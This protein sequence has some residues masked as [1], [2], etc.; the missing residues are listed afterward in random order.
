MDSSFYQQ[1]PSTQFSPDNSSSSDSF[2]SA[3]LPFNENDTQEM[4]LYGI[5]E[6]EEGRGGAGAATTTTTKEEICNY[7][8][9][10]R[11]PWGKYAAEI[12][13][14]TRNGI[15]VWIGTFD[16]AE[17]AA[18]AYDQAAFAMR[19]PSTALN[20]PVEVVYESL[21]EMN[22]GF[23]EGCS[24]VLAM[25]K[26]HSMNRKS[27]TKTTKKRN[28]KNNNNNN[29]VINNREFSSLDNVLVLED[30][31]TDYL[32][33]LLSLSETSAPW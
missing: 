31:G 33:E 19:G 22:Y 16:T 8:G 26:R 27:S 20:F 24:P 7:R 2:N 4:L 25:K 21:K 17:E 23:Q 3:Y 12:R 15:R 29:D 5:L 6:A 30:L 18:L 32:E 13:D 10:R 1:C 11:R 28:N 14:S 9:V